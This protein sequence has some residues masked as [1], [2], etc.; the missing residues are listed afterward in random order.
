MIQS[1]VIDDN[2]RLDFYDTPW[3][4]RSLGMKTREICALE[5]SHVESLNTLLT[6]LDY[7]N[8]V[9]GI[10]LICLRI[11]GRNQPLKLTLQQNGYRFVETSLKMKLDN[12]E[13]TNLYKAFR[14]NIN[15]E[16][17]EEEDFA[18]IR[19]IAH[20]DFAFGR[21]HEDPLIPGE[22]AGNRYYYWIDEL[23]KQGK[24]FLI[25]KKN[26]LVISFLAYQLKDSGAEFVLGGSKTSHGYMSY[27]FWSA[28]LD[29][30]KKSGIKG[31]QTTISAANLGILNLYIKF[32]FTVDETLFGF[33]KQYDR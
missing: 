11:Q 32:G 16:I 21:F 24:E 14:T 4:T 30:L 8:E 15:I 1:V 12:L 9:D 31:I 20:D 22:R 17:P 7:K 25:F 13:R 3:N 27:Y 23:T 33:H 2:N 26:N 5:F 29:Y 19:N 18:Q 6:K 28:V 10:Q